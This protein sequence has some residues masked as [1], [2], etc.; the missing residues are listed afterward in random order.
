MSPEETDDEQR[1]LNH[2]QW[3][4]FMQ[5][6]VRSGRRPHLGCNVPHSCVCLP[7][8]GGHKIWADRVRIRTSLKNGMLKYQRVRPVA[9]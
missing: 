7:F 2:S 3:P 1:E 9:Y 8:W 4:P 5:R 6:E